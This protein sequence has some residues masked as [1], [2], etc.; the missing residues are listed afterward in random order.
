[1]AELEH[2]GTILQRV[3]DKHQKPTEELTDEEQDRFMQWVWDNYRPDIE[4][5]PHWHPFVREEWARVHK[6]NKENRDD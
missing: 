2:I 3:F 6:L 5:K 1:M 4:P